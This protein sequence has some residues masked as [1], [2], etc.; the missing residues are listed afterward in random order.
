MGGDSHYQCSFDPAGGVRPKHIGEYAGVSSVFRDFFALFRNTGTHRILLHECGNRPHDRD[1][2]L[3]DLFCNISV[4][5]ESKMKI[6]T[7][8]VATQRKTICYNGKS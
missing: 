6:A 2:V 1:R 7:A 4:W 8:M 5:E 3:R